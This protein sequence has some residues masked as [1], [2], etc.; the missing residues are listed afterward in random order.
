MARLRTAG[1]LFKKNGGA[2][3]KLFG[4]LFKRKDQITSKD[5]EFAEVQKL[6]NELE[7]ILTSVGNDLTKVPPL[8]EFLSKSLERSVEVSDALRKLQ[9]DIGSFSR[10]LERN[11]KLVQASESQFKEES[12]WLI[13]YPVFQQGE[14]LRKDLVF[15]QLAY[16][17]DQISLQNIVKQMNHFLGGSANSGEENNVWALFDQINDKKVQLLVQMEASPENIKNQIERLDDFTEGLIGFRKEVNSSKNDLEGELRSVNR[18][19]DQNIQA[20]AKIIGEF[21][22]IKSNI[23]PYP[24]IVKTDS[25]K[26]HLMAIQRNYEMMQDSIAATASRLDRFL[27]GDL[28]P[29]VEMARDTYERI[30]SKKSVQLVEIEPQPDLLAIQRE[31]LDD[32]NRLI[33]EFK[34]VLEDMEK[35]ITSLDTAIRAEEEGLVDDSLRYI[36]LSERKPRSFD[37]NDFPYQELHISFS[38]IET[39]MIASRKSLTDLRESRKD[40]ISHVAKMD[41]VKTNSDQYDRFKRLQDDFGEANKTGK[42]RLKELDDA[43]EEFRTVIIDNFLNTPEFWALQYF[44]EE[45]SSRRSGNTTKENLGYLLDLNRFRAEKYHGHLVS[46]FQLKLSKKGASNPSFEL[47]F[48]GSNEFPVGGVQLLNGSGEVVFESLRDSVIS[49]AEKDDDTL[50]NFEWVIQISAKILSQIVMDNE[51]S[52]RILYATVSNRI[53]LTG[54]T[55]KVYKEYRIPEARLENWRRM[56]GVIEGVS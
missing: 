44:V 21:E 53:N 49:K 51:H 3:E 29:V 33:I 1:P 54:Y 38:N 40:I 13:N 12:S 28:P 15:T 2:Y 31:R 43:I 14:R 11:R 10:D 23:Y 55:T 18:E 19:V 30:M 24:I 22:A 27:S 45:I 17:D 16:S 39:K 25:V 52:V 56:L 6:A 41:G 47:L 5:Q 20:N 42:R 26:A 36:S 9:K 37:E 4:G 34:E 48:T 7:T 8:E 35:D 46:D 50:V 32:L